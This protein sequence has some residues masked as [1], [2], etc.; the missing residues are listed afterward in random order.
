MNDVW[1]LSRRQFVKITGFTLGAGLA[2]LS[3]T[4]KAYAKAKG[5]LTDRLAAIYEHD[6]EMKYRKSQ[7]N[8]A[9]KELYGHFLEHPN[10]HMAHH[11]LHT[12][13]VDRSAQV[14]ALKDKGMKL[15]L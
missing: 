2:G 13:Y 6:T 11:L 1:A 14:K 15:K 10:S 4:S 8:P 12:H 5:Y 3:F 7:D 9:V